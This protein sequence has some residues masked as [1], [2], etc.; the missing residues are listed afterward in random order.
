MH[1][2]STDDTRRLSMTVNSPDDIEATY[3][4]TIT[5][6]KGASIVRMVNYILGDETFK[7]GLTVSLMLSIVLSY[8]CF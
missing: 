8:I 5:Y 2:D 6:G 1:S 7:R 3:N 4:P